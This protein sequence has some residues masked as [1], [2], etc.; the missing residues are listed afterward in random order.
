MGKVLLRRN[1]PQS[2]VLYLRHAEK[3]DPSNFITHNLLGQAFRSL[4]Q[5]QEAKQEFDVAAKIHAAEDVKSTIRNG[6][7][8]VPGDSPQSSECGEI[9]PLAGSLLVS[10]FWVGPRSA[11]RAHNGLSTL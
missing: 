5:E 3:M 10:N 4:G 11:S 8:R 7:Q 6:S 2:A 9:L 1:D